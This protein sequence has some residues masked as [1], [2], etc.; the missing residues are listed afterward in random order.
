LGVL[1]AQQHFKLVSTDAP[2]FGLAIGKFRVTTL[3][4]LYSLCLDRGDHEI[5]WHWHPSG[6]SQEQRPHMHLSFVGDAHLLCA[7]H[8][9]EDVVESCIEMSDG[10]AACDD[11]RDRLDESR[12]LHTEHRSWVDWPRAREAVKEIV[13]EAQQRLKPR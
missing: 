8:T 13:D 5:G 1:K 4:Y 6:K 3:S 12:S 10:N 9:F 2:R 11:W 7:R